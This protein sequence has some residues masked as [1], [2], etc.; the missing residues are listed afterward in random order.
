MD[1][2]Q[3][4][5]FIEA[6]DLI[7]RKEYQL[8]IN[9]LEQLAKNKNKRAIFEL[10]NV[11]KLI[12][13]EFYKEKI[14]NLLVLSGELGYDNSYFELGLIF[15]YDHKYE[16]A[17]RYFEKTSNPYKYLYLGVIE[18]NKKIKNYS[19]ENAV[20]YFIKGSKKNIKKCNYYLSICYHYGYGV[21]KNQEKE[22]LYYSKAK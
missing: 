21:S 2:N 13:K 22:I 16:L 20:K 9:Q 11:Y 7:E 5:Q 18:L 15:Y 6:Q 17:Y 14:I 8:A 12:N 4:E 3:Y 10:A 1:K 19:L